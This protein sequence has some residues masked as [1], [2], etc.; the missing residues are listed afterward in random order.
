M[1]P[2]V[3]LP[4]PVF[5]LLDGVGEGEYRKPFSLCPQEAKQA[6]GEVQ[7]ESEN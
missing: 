1:R 2:P 4:I 3:N 7:I 6:S 5:G